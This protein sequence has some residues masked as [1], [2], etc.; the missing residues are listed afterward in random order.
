MKKLTLFVVLLQLSMHS[1][2]QDT[3]ALTAALN[4][5][6]DMTLLRG[7]H[8]I[9]Y[10]SSAT[11][12]TLTLTLATHLLQYSAENSAMFANSKIPS[13]LPFLRASI[14]VC[15]IMALQAQLPGV[16]AFGSAGSDAVLGITLTGKFYDYVEISDNKP[17]IYKG[18]SQEFQFY[19]RA[20]NLFDI[21]DSLLSVQL[22][23]C[24]ETA[25]LK[26]SS[27]YLGAEISREQAESMV[28]D[29]AY[30]P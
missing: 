14:N 22:D 23:H 18:N 7:D 12:Q 13:S 3:S 8:V 1:F 30:K 17:S 27:L 29:L 4:V 24:T 2:S 15:D 20:D 10:S 19:S 5:S 9:R 11:N 21:S 28:D 25:K 26:L 6:G 16:G